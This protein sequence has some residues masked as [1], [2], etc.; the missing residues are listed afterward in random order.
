MRAPHLQELFYCLLLLLSPLEKEASK[1]ASQKSSPG[2][3]RAKGIDSQP[4]FALTICLLYAILTFPFATTIPQAPGGSGYCAVYLALLE[5]IC[6]RPP[7]GGPSVAF[8]LLET[9][10][11]FIT[12]EAEMG[13]TAS[14]KETGLKSVM[15]RLCATRCFLQKNVQ[16]NGEATVSTKDF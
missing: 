6:W 2:C 7:W 4:V 13:A 15:N 8:H 5:A 1:V 12:T 9:K 16:L 11:A 14:L 3:Y 10:W